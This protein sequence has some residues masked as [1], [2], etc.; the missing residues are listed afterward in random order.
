MAH[1]VP[2]HR[3]MTLKMAKMVGECRNKRTKPSRLYRSSVDEDPAIQ[4]SNSE[5]EAH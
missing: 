5:G 1:L 2:R 3:S 4:S